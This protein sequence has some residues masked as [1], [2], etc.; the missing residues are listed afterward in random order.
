MLIVTKEQYPS[1]K[2]KLKLKTNTDHSYTS[3]PNFTSPQHPF[4]CLSAPSSP[5]A[6]LLIRSTNALP[7]LTPL[8]TLQ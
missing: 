6:N 7:C 2:T 5:N 3:S 4:P 8:G 1:Q